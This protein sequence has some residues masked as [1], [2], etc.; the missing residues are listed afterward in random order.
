[1]E[2]NKKPNLSLKL[3]IFLII[4]L[5]VVLFA[6]SAVGKVYNVW[7]KE[8]DGKAELAEAEWTKKVSIEEA[9]AKKE[10]AVYEAEAEV[11]RAK[12]VAESNRIIADGLKDNEAYLRYLWINNL[13]QS[14]Q[15]IYVP[16]EAG[17]PILEAGKRK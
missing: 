2:L 11:E 8:M 15:V 16:T 9:K 14:N 17:L 4:A 10:S 3:I 12:G 13:K 6:F 5:M 7:S 1:M